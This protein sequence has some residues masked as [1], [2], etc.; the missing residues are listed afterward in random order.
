MR[1]RLLALAIAL[2]ALGAGTRAACA[3]PDA[4]LHPPLL[5]LTLSFG[6]FALGRVG[7]PIRLPLALW[8]A[9]GMVGEAAALALWTW[10]GQQAVAV[11]LGALAAVAWVHFYHQWSHRHLPDAAP[12][13]RP[14]RIWVLALL[15]GLAPLAVLVAGGRPPG[16]AW[17]AA[18]LLA[19]AAGAAGA[20]VCTGL[21][22][23]SGGA[24]ALEAGSGRAPAGGPPVP[25]AAVSAVVPTAQA[26][27]AATG[28]SA[29]AAG[30]R[31]WDDGRG[32]LAAVLR[33]WRKVY[34]LGALGLALAAGGAV[35]VVGGWWPLG[36]P[37]FLVGFSAVMV[38]AFAAGAAPVLR[39]PLPPEAAADGRTAV[40]VIHG[41]GQQRRY[42]TLYALTGGLQDW[43][44]CPVGR[45]G[46]LQSAAEQVALPVRSWEGLAQEDLIGYRVHLA[47]DEAPARPV[48]LFEVFW[49]PL[50]QRKQSVAGV[51]RWAGWILLDLLS[52][53]PGLLLYGG[54]TP[55]EAAA[56]RKTWQEIFYV[57]TLL[58]AAA[59]ALALVLA[60]YTAALTSVFWPATGTGAPPPHLLRPGVNW[61]SLHPEDP[62]RVQTER[63]AAA[64]DPARREPWLTLP[65]RMGPGCT[66]TVTLRTVTEWLSGGGP[67]G[68]AWPRWAAL[69]LV[70][71]GGLALWRML[72]G[73]ASAAAALGA[74]RRNPAARPWPRRLPRAE[75]RGLLLS[76]FAARGATFA[77]WS[78]VLV[79][80]AVLA[81]P[82]RAYGPYADLSGL[83]PLSL[84][85]T[86][87]AGAYQGVRSFVAE[88]LGDIP[89][90]IAF[91]EKAETFAI[92]QAVRDKAA[93]VLAHALSAYD[94]VIVVGHSLGSVIG[95][96]ALTSLY[97]EEQ[98]DA[99]LR[100]RLGK[101]R[102]FI[103]IG[104][105]LV[106]VRGLL[107]RRAAAPQ[108]MDGAVFRTGGN[109]G[110]IPWYNFWL[111]TDLVGGPLAHGYPIMPGGDIQIPWGA[112]GFIWSH[113]DYWR[114]RLFYENLV[115]LALRA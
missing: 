54:G 115:R 61:A 23:A 5:A 40:V 9:G 65:F 99:A 110:G 69:A 7:T 24:L 87:G 48:E 21:A 70:F 15:T 30:R 29:R 73:L 56:V 75:S 67:G 68:P 80:I 82:L 19:L 3:L 43:Q 16:P 91:D 62:T 8:L 51:V 104:S 79:I 59:A 11:L 55:R 42:E 88:F 33:D 28:E 31:V 53:A 85:L 63:C 14:G 47:A 107:E 37:V 83:F 4:G 20:A 46:E 44:S 1:A 57:L 102:A 90:Y 50:T 18:A 41:I 39:V 84:M 112:A 113:S 22:L 52:G 111:L 2:A 10:P 45:C 60:L 89:T 95:R 34:A 106:K 66:S 93:R 76:R 101:V 81:A 114:A 6:S 26:E 27:T 109:P 38:M 32:E 74:L 97:Q 17:S 103:S 13:P 35:L 36:Y 58:S 72:G 96:D 105:P 77:F 108:G 49:A 12:A 78:G 100:G 86:I 98:Q 94:R 92:R 25:G 71:L 64:L